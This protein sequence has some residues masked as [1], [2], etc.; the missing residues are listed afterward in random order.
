[1]AET[2]SNDENNLKWSYRGVTGPYY[3]G[4]LNDDF[5]LCNSGRNQSPI[6]LIPGFNIRNHSP[7]SPPKKMERLPRLAFHYKLTPVNLFNDGNTI[8]LKYQPGSYMKVGGEKFQLLNLHFHIPSEHLVMGRSS[9]MEVHLVHKNA[10]QQT[11]IV[12][13]M[14]RRGMRNRK[15]Q[16]LWDYLP[17]KN[18]TKLKP[19]I[20]FNARGV[21][22]LIKSYFYYMGSMTSPPCTENVHWYVLKSPGILSELQIMKFRYHIPYNARPVQRLYQRQIFEK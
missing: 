5:K 7:F 1:M 2:K 20:L 11:A 22:P 21:M 18:Q 3:W 4:K 16:S 14:L 13:V 6:N 10:K 17:A 8:T 12:S 9:E 19:R 15:L